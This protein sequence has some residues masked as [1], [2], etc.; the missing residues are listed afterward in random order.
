MPSTEDRQRN[1]CQGERQRTVAKLLPAERLNRNMPC[2]R[3]TQTRASVF[4]LRAKAHR[5]KLQSSSE[6]TYVFTLCRI[7]LLADSSCSFWLVI[8]IG[9]ES[10]YPNWPHSVHWCSRKTDPS[11][12]RRRN[13]LEPPTTPLLHSSSHALLSLVV[14]LV[15]VQT[16]LDILTRAVPRSSLIA[17]IHFSYSSRKTK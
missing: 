3:M 16:L 13:P 6:R 1:N 10:P 4:K 9:L 2:R 7:K 14:L 17:V 11:F 15:F 5:E 8:L 12:T